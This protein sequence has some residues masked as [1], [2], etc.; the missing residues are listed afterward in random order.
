MTSN[1]RG[2]AAD[3]T[4]RRSVGRS[5]SGSPSRASTLGT[6]PRSALG[7]WRTSSLHIAPAIGSTPTEAAAP[8]RTVTLPICGTA[9]LQGID[10]SHSPGS[11]FP[12]SKLDSR[13]ARVGESVV[14][15]LGSGGRGVEPPRADRVASGLRPSTRP[16]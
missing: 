15:S 4:A 14:G 3:G 12:T 16:G 2:G 1:R 7:A 8:A 10:R 11:R 5:R 13:P 9:P 6:S